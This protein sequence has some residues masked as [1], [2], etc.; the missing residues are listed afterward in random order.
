MTQSV[1]ILQNYVT[2]LLKNKQED[3]ENKTPL[4]GDK[5]TLVGYGTSQSEDKHQHVLPEPTHACTKGTK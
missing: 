2:Y 3:P 1:R 5:P 4:G